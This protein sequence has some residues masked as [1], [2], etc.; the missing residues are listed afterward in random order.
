M[1]KRAAVVDKKTRVLPRV[2][3][4]VGDYVHVNINSDI[5]AA[6]LVHMTSLSLSS[7]V[8]KPPRAMS[9]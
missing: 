2:E 3:S 4:L 6:Y 9:S 5:A 7:N 1:G 8:V